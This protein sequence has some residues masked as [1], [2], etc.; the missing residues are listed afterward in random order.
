M[1]A[2]LQLEAAVAALGIAPHDE[3]RM[4]P[5]DGA[6]GTVRGDLGI[7]I[8]KRPG[9]IGRAVENALPKSAGECLTQGGHGSRGSGLRFAWRFDRSDGPHLFRIRKNLLIIARGVLLLNRLMRDQGRGRLRLIVQWNC[10]RMVGGSVSDRRSP[11]AVIP[12]VLRTARC[13]GALFHR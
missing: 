3:A 1:P 6:H 7:R 9:E 12:V 2:Q 13:R 5:S 4:L 10:W 8:V 11:C